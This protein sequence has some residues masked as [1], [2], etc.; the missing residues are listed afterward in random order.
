M[1]IYNIRLTTPITPTFRTHQVA[2]LFDLS[3]DDLA[4]ERFAHTLTAELPGLDED[5][6]IGAIVGPSGSGK[7][8]LARAAYG[9]ALH[10]PEPWPDDVAIIEA[11]ES[12]SRRAGGTYSFKDLLRTLTAVGLASPPSWLKPYRVLSTGERFRADLARALLGAGVQGS[13]FK[14]QSC[15]R[16]ST[17]N[18]EPGTL[19]H[20]LLVFDEFTSTLDRS[21][22]CTASYA[23]AKYLRG[24]KGSEVRVQGFAT[25]TSSPGSRQTGFS[26]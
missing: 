18:L 23:L 12:T 1:P 19:N 14:V 3:L 17:L 24:Q 15:Q 2:G 8:T 10:N 9:A 5:W 7:T 13:T 16:E 4:G 20:S 11:L 25:P 6:T 21:V 22:A 26:I